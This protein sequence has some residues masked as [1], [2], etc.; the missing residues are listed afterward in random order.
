MIE[1]L[2]V[3]LFLE[4]DLVELDFDLFTNVNKWIF[5]SKKDV[6]KTVKENDLRKRTSTALHVLSMCFLY[7]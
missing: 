4:F 6:G 7:S 2:D 5:L 3:F 1:W